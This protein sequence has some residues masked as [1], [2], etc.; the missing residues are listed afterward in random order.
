MLTHRLTHGAGGEWGNFNYSEVDYVTAAHEQD[1]RQKSN[2]SAERQLSIVDEGDEVL[3]TSLAL[4][5]DGLRVNMDGK[6]LEKWND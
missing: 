2:F 3:G 4:A 5:Y 6:W 1:Q